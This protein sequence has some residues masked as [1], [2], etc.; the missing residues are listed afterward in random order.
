MQSPETNNDFLF[1]CDIPFWAQNKM[2]VYLNACHTAQG[3]LLSTEGPIS[4]ARAFAVGG[5][6]CIFTTQWATDDVFASR[7]AQKVYSGLKENHNKAEALRIAQLDLLANSNSR[8]A[9]PYYWAN[10]SL[11]GNTQPI[12]FQS[13]WWNYLS[14]NYG[15]LILILSCFLAFTF[16]LKRQL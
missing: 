10:L 1:A 11:F 5:S 6:E 15:L 16:F 2:M 4:L 12:Q 13:T 7:L 9:H 3:E 14:N 8:T